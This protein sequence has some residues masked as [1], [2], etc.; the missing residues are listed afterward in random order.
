MAEKFSAIGIRRLFYG[1]VIKSVNTPLDKETGQGGLSKLEL[2]ELIPTLTEVLNVHQD[3]W[4]Y[5]EAEATI[6]RYR[7]QLTD[8]P[9]RQNEEPGDV[10]IS[11]TIGQYDFQ[12]K[13]DLQGGV[14][15]AD[16][17]SRPSITKEISKTIVALTED[18]YYIVLTNA[19]ISARGSNTDNAIGLAVVAS[20]MESKVEGLESEKWFLKDAVDAAV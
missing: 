6:T 14:A 8:K 1:D 3:T 10:S 17:W 4:S 13:A 18:G 16:S 20:P 12:T 9:Y 15:T 7:N 19:T 5:E 11:F 2:K